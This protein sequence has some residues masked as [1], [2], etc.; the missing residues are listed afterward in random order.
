MNGQVREAKKLGDNQQS[1]A[2]HGLI[3][4]FN[5]GINSMKFINRIQYIVLTLALNALSTSA[6][7]QTYQYHADV[8]GMVCAYCAYSVSKNI[9]KI[10]GVYIDSVDVDLEDGKLDFISN[11]LVPEKTLS[12]LF[13]ESGFSISNLAY[14]IIPGEPEKL[15]N[16]ADLDLTIKLSEI[17]QFNKIF[18]IIGNI[19]ASSS[20]RLV[21]KAP[22]SQEN[23]ILKP[24]LMG[25]Q[26][27]VKVHFISEE[28][29]KIHLQLWLFA[30]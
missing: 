15:T 1:H 14:K 24:L 28:S 17:E 11:Q 5:S 30:D 13:S 2:G 23:S 10:Q 21:I 6:F 26:Q 12:K 25:R 19:A 8:K 18:E 4:L 9:K 3:T 16:K 7:A 20:S 22:A 27:V 29:N